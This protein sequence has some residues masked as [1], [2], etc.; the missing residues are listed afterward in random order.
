MEALRDKD[1]FLVYEGATIALGIKDGF[2][3][4]WFIYADD[5]SVR[6]FIKDDGYEVV[7][8]D[9][10]DKPSDYEP[11]KYRFINGKFEPSG[12]W[13]PERTLKELIE[14]LK[15]QVNDFSN[16]ILTQYSSIK[17][18]LITVTDEIQEALCDADEAYNKKIADVEEAL[19]ELSEVVG[20][21]S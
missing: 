17:A 2:G 20:G 12:M 18:Q 1:K 13:T 3:T 15:Q 11:K 4:G 6:A 7:S 19:C 14:E 5:G 21:A 16:D 10:T 8:F 9:I